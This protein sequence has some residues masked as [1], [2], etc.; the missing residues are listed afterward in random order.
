M[1]FHPAAVLALPFLAGACASSGYEPPLPTLPSPAH[2]PPP[3][4]P[5][6]VAP[7]ET[8]PDLPPEDPVKAAS[9]ALRGGLVKPRREWFKGL[10]YVPPYHPNHGY[11]V[12]VAEGS[13]TNLQFGKR[14]IPE[15]ATCQ[16]A[17]VILSVAWT[18]TGSGASESWMLQAKAKVQGEGNGQIRCSVTTNR[19]PYTVFFKTMPVSSPAHIATVRWSDPYDFL[20]P[21]NGVK[22][23][24]V[25]AGTDGN[26]R[27]TGDLGAFGLTPGRVTNDG[28]HTCLRFPPSAAF[29]LPAAWLVEGDAERPASPQTI[30]GAYLIDGVPPV[31]E[32]RTDHATIRIERLQRKAP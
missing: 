11:L 16:D 20:A 22:S 9:A 30:N 4:V 6:V 10:A 21:D 26:Y 27:L 23:A 3:V 19:G 5:V 29:D 1:K 32:L 14:E 15:T 24:P 31:I 18:Q 17:G 13:Q 28:A 12:Y 25:C 7:P 8:L 2:A